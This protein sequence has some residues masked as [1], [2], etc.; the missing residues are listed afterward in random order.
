MI[1]WG[2]CGMGCPKEPMAWTAYTLQGWTEGKDFVGKV[3]RFCGWI[4]I[5][6]QGKWNDGMVRSLEDIWMTRTFITWFWM[7]VGIQLHFP[8][9]TGI[10]I[11]RSTDSLSLPARGPAHVSRDGE[12]RWCGSHIF[13][14]PR[15]SVYYPPTL[16][17][18]S[19]IDGCKELRLVCSVCTLSPEDEGHGSWWVFRERSGL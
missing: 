8:K 2:R 6:K 14:Y 7:K 19:F 18:V 12:R 9:P 4:R 3:D 15:E 10:A 17:A 1:I 13:V 16:C 11:I 5:R